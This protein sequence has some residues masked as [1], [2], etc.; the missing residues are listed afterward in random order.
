M[1]KAGQLLRAIVLDSASLLV[2]IH[3]GLQTD[4]ITQSH[5]TCLRASPYSTT[6]VVPNVQMAD[7][8]SLSPDGDFL[9]YKGKLYVP[10]YQATQLDVLCSCHDH[11]LSG[12]PGITKMIKNIRRQFYWPKMVAFI[13]DHIHSCAVCCH[14]KS[15]HH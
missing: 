14:R 1:F 5:I 3:Y 12:H 4:P 15:I 13:T 11:R 9:C 8:W 2:S 6:T 10:D 7:P